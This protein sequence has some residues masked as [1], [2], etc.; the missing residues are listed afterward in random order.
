MFVAQEST[1]P[2][3]YRKARWSRQRKRG[4]KITHAGSCVVGAS[5]IEGY[6]GIAAKEIFS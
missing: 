5:S 3:L 4:T 6:A 2:R 1:V